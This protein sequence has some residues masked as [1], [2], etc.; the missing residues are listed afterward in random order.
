MF[1]TPFTAM[2]LAA[3]AVSAGPRV[4][5][6]TPV[7]P[8]PAAKQLAWQR[9]ELTMFLHFGINTFTDREWGEGT[10]D[11]ALFDPTALDCNQWARV[12]RE[13]GFKLLILTA[14]HHD[15]FCLWPSA[16]TK[17]SVKR[18]PWK[19][20]KGDV[21]R[22]FTEACRREG[23]KVGL[24][25]SPWDRNQPSYG[26]SPKY[27]DYFC[28]QLTELMTRYGVIDE[29]WFD[30]ACGEGPNGKRQVYDWQR[31][32]DTVYRHNPNAL[33]AICGPDIRW[34][35][36]ESGVAR[37][38]ES[39]VQPRVQGRHTGKAAKV[40][41]PAEC[42]VSIRPGWFYHP[43]Q[44]GKV[45]SLEHLANIYF[46]SVG[47]NSVLLLNVPP[48]RRGLLADP[49]VG[50]LHEFRKLLDDTF[51]TN[52]AASGGVTA[53]AVRGND[54]RFGPSRMLDGNLDTYWAAADGMTAGTV[55]FRLPRP[56]A[57]NVVKVQECLRFGE[58]VEKYHLEARV[59][60]DW[61]TV[62]EGRVIG[63]KNLLRFPSLTSD[64]VR[65]VIDRAKA[66]PVIAEFGL[67]R[68]PLEPAEG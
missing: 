38:G 56:V 48:D 60:A 51:A 64:R 62:A 39:S 27:N 18:S 57:F 49:D 44:D 46:Q 14:K 59:G 61:K 35:G 25:L 19:N 65:L 58:R 13:A 31:Y 22:E 54:D 12:A 8:V 68:C 16:Y 6:P 55:E 9:L 32:Y 66:C 28:N 4:H 26:D 7:L 15:G 37:V 47:R 33:I 53:S 2:T 10:E 63:H 52:L 43:D 23:L 40:W 20:G 24:Y 45:K 1:L 3:G 42:D 21:V 11:E 29:V 17:H 5:P 30:G 50:R 34:V 67:Y 36:N 41:Y